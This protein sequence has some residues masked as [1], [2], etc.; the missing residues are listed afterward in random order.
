MLLN[1][2][3]YQSCKEQ[4]FT[5]CLVPKSR[6]TLYDSMDC[7]ML[8]SSAHEIPQARILECIAIFCSERRLG[9]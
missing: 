6:L 3:Q 2:N 5:S 8:D 1:H 4:S 9:V 7:S